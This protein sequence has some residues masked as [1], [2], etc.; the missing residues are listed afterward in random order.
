MDNKINLLITLTEGIQLLRVA[1]KITP[2]MLKGDVMPYYLEPENKAQIAKLLPEHCKSGG[3]NI[4]EVQEIFEIKDLVLSAKIHQALAEERERVRGEIEQTRKKLA[5][6]V[7]T[8]TNEGM[9]RYLLGKIDV[10][11][12]LL[13]SLDK[14]LQVDKE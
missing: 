11:D 13:D 9:E 8:V 6:K 7:M 5:E 4:V 12:D 1:I 2:D 10:L 3:Y 14:T